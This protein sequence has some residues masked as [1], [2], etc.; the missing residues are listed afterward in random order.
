MISTSDGT[1]VELEE[2]LNNLLNTDTGLKQIIYLILIGNY[3][4]IYELG[5]HQESIVK[6]IFKLKSLKFLRC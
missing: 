1:N 3:S 4:S 6:S 2:C 5:K